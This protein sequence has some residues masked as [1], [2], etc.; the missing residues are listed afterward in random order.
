MKNKLDALHNHLF[1]IKILST[2]ASHSCC[3]YIWGSGDEKVQGEVQTPAAV[4]TS[5]DEKVQGEIQTPAAVCTSGDEKVQGEAQTS[6]TK[7]TL[8]I[9]H[10]NNCTLKKKTINIK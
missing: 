1:Y 2:H 8:G 4:C 7:S 5:G 6:K 9:H 3:L 10:A